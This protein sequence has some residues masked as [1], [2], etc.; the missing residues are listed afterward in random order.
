[1]SLQDRVDD[2]YDWFA[3]LSLSV[4]IW[5]ITLVGGL[6]VVPLTRGAS[7]GLFL[8]GLLTGLIARLMYD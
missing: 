6:L 5:L 4:R 1:V 8:A 2:A 3:A 7:I